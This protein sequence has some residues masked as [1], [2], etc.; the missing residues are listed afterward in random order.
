VQSDIKHFPFKVFNKAGKPY[1]RVEY[2][3]EQK[4]FVRSVASY[5]LN[6]LAN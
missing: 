6:F 1:I 4:E 2:R 3:G 5:R